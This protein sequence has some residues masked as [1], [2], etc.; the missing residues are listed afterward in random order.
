MSQIDDGE[1]NLS[2]EVKGQVERDN[3]KLVPVSES[4]RY[5]RRAQS[6]ERQVEALTE[7]LAEAKSEA[8]KMS[9]QIH[10]VRLE[11]ELVRN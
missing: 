6:A 3:L 1:A 9:E 4:I 8:K 10:E 5:R 2:L 7:E 11:Q